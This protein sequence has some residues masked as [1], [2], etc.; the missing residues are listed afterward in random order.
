MTSALCRFTAAIM[1]SRPD[2]QNGEIQTMKCLGPEFQ[3]NL[4]AEILAQTSNGRGAQRNG[5][6][7]IQALLQGNHLR[8][9]SAISLHNVPLDVLMKF[10]HGSLQLRVHLGRL[11][12]QLGSKQVTPVLAE[13]LVDRFCQ[14]LRP[15]QISTFRVF[16]SAASPHHALV[17]GVVVIAVNSPFIGCGFGGSCAFR[18]FEAPW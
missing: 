7:K 12:W 3:H 2:K 9:L 6:G 16:P 17:G 13:A 8:F 10:L 5:A 1:A 11:L 14:L 4:E 18:P 15:I